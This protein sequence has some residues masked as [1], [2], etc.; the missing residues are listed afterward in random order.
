M[1]YKPYSIEWSRKRYLAESI[2]QY[3]DANVEPEII[4][5]DI[6]SILK[7]QENNYKNLFEK[8]NFISESIKEIK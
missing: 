2:Q 1:N 4:L 8:Y 6:L 5:Q 7:E 3:F